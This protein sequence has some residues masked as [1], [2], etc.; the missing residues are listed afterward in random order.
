MNDNHALWDIINVV[1]RRILEETKLMSAGYIGE[2]CPQNSGPTCCGLFCIG[3]QPTGVCG[4]S[5][6]ATSTDDDRQNVAPVIC[7]HQN[8]NVVVH[9]EII[10]LLKKGNAARMYHSQIKVPANM[11][12]VDGLFCP[13]NWE[14]CG[15]KGGCAPKKDFHCCS[16]VSRSHLELS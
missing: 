4:H 5:Q 15:N 16:Y 13:E 6:N 7:V 8:G 11:F 2:C 9:Q 12:R 10:V 3:L 14:C 1:C